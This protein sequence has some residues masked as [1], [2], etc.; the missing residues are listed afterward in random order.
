[1]YHVY[2][3]IFGKYQQIPFLL[4]LF[5]QKQTMFTATVHI[6]GFKGSPAYKWK[7][8]VISQKNTHLILI[9]LTMYDIYEKVTHDIICYLHDRNHGNNIILEMLGYV[10]VSSFDNFNY[11]YI[12]FIVTNNISNDA[13]K[14]FG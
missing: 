14:Q 13:T 12:L 5:E 2:L 9:K 7:T 3:Q 1:M 6:N 8:Y 4:F 11:K 10:T